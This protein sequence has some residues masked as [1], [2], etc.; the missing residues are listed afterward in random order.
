MK[1]KLYKYSDGETIEIGQFNATDLFATPVRKFEHKW[2]IG[3]TGTHFYDL[4]KELN[5]PRTTNTKRDTQRKAGK[6]F[7]DFMEMLAADMIN[8]HAIFVLP[9]PNGGWLYIADINAH[10]KKKFFNPKTGGKYYVP[11][12]HRGRAM[13]YRKSAL[14][15]VRFNQAWRLHL[16]K[17]V[18]EGEKYYA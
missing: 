16:Y 4:A 3:H 6:I 1:P 11:V 10:N 17:K 14:Y 13:H 9:M 12:L 18:L 7:C 15:T 5:I 2:G 8:E